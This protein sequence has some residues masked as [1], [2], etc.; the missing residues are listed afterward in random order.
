MSG[1][2][3]SDAAAVDLAA[4]GDGLGAPAQNAGSGVVARVGRRWWLWAIGA[5]MGVIAGSVYLA[6][7]DQTYTATSVLAAEF[8]S[9]SATM[10]PAG[11]TPPDDFLFQQ[12][13]LI[14]SPNVLSTAATTALVPALKP[15][16]PG[17][18]VNVQKGEGL[19]TIQ[20]NSRRPEE[21]ARIANAVADAYLRTRNDQQSSSTSGLTELTKQRDA[22]A[23][24]RAA[25]EKALSDFRQSASVGSSDADRAVAQR[26]EQLSAALTTAQVEAT[27]SSAAAAAA[28]DLLVDPAKLKQ[29]VEANRSKGIFAG[30]DA[31]RTQ[32][33]AELKTLEP[34]LERQ[35]DSMLPQHPVVVSTQKKIDATKAKLA[36]FDKQYGPVYAA[37]VEQ[38][39]VTSEKKV[40]ELQALVDQQSKQHKDFAVRTTK[41]AELEVELKKSDASLAEID[42]KI[43]DITIAG[44]TPDAPRVSVVQAANAPQRPSSPDRT[45]ALSIAA[46]IGLLAGVLLAALVPST[47]GASRPPSR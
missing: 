43:R 18:N 17:L 4:A 44:G 27:Q 7:A 45:R 42:R 20:V 39:R 6:T 35:K 23:I 38:A 47:G 19:I 8:P 29:L 30:L 46:G 34:Q 3:A 12:R 37:Y 24:E 33:E 32:I 2:N 15:G 11:P 25:K 13:S 41:L 26:M 28:K 9:S 31:Q 5:A 16:Y 14:L 10:G 1:P 21:A 36:D 40:A 22:L